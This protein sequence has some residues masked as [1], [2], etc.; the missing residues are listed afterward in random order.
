MKKRIELLFNNYTSPP[1][2]VF[3]SPFDEVIET[4][5]II[6][7]Y[8]LAKDLKKDPALVWFIFVFMSD[9]LNLPGIIGQTTCVESTLVIISESAGNLNRIITS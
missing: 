6:S 4:L 1:L 8:F 9:I 7:S 5:G 3:N 2:I